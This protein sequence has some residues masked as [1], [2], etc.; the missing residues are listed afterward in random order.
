MILSVSERPGDEMAENGGSPVARIPAADF[1]KSGV[2]ARW[3]PSAS[4]EIH[5]A[6]DP[7]DALRSCRRF[8]HDDPWCVTVARQDFAYKGGCESGVVVTARAYPRFPS[9]LADLTDKAARLALL[10]LDD[11]CQDTC[12]LVA[13]RDSV[14]LT[15]RDS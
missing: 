6:G 3:C 8:V 1:A 14:W 13:G 11:L 4:V 10:L 12:L 7:A 5:V 2:T 15:R 9:T